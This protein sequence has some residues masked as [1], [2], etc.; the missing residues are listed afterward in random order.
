MASS[1]V[2]LDNSGNPWVFF[3]TGRYMSN[4]DKTDQHAQYLVGV[5]D[6]VLNG[7]CVQT[8][9][10]D[11]QDQDLLDVTSAE[12]CISCSSG[13]QVQ[14]MGSTTTFTGLE[15]QI[16]GNASAG[17]PAKDGWVI[18]LDAHSGSPDF[19]AERS[20]VNPT[21]IGGAV[22]FPTFTP[23]RDP[24]VAQGNSSVY[25]L[26]YKTGTGHTDPIMGVDDNGM[27]KRSVEIGQGLASA[28]AIQIT[29]DPS[30]MSGIVQT[31]DASLHPFKSKPPA[32]LWSQYLGWIAQRV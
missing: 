17:I 4:A 32:V 31:T 22:F 10:T 11:C 1:S 12:I 6:S 3:G 14:G 26:Y 7:S 27:A 8:T 13:T 2:T 28:V 20:V 23:D 18:Q 25:G 19:G 16:Q 24:C 29:G 9:A 15:E 5:K 21:L 30:G